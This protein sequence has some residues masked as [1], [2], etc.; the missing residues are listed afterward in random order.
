MSIKIYYA[1]KLQLMNLKELKIFCD[2]VREKFKLCRNNYIKE[3]YDEEFYKKEILIP[4]WTDK[5]NFQLDF[6]ATISFFP[7]K[8]CILCVPMC[9]SIYIEEFNKLPNIKEYGY[10]N[11]TDKPDD[12]SNKEWRDRKLAWETVWTDYKSPSSDSFI[13]NLLDNLSLPKYLYNENEV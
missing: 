9:H 6:T 11:N 8:K 13:Y 1:Y 7:Y 4:H 12:I 2:N 3:N 10:W 5:I